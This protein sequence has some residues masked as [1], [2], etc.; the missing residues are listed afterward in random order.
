MVNKSGLEKLSP[1]TGVV[2]V[3]LIAVGAGLFGIY[4]YLPP[5]EVLRDHFLENDTIVYVS[6][7]LGTLS[8]FFFIWFAGSLFITLRASEGAA[9]QFSMLSFGGGLASGVALAAGFSYMAASG[10]RAGAAGGISLEEAVTL[11][12]AYGQ[13]LGGMLA[14][15][16]AVFIGAAAVVFLRAKLFP[17]WFGWASVLIAIGLLTPIAYIILAF[18]LIW[19]LVVSVWLYRANLSTT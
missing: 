6:G 17:N 8:A 2:A 10:A 11:Y 13:I 9:G 4:E 19:L 3:I 15:T 14:I 5:A 12:D 16:L 18:A 1:L 7:Y